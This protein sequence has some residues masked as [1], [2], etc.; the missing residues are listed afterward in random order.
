MEAGFTN[1]NAVAN[2]KVVTKPMSAETVSIDLPPTLCLRRKHA[3]PKVRPSAELGRISC[4]GLDLI[5]T[6]RS[7]RCL[8]LTTVCAKTVVGS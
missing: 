1:E 2:W 5:L 8:V 3:D 4:L 7:C 6:S